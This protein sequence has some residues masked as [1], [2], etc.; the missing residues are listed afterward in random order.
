MGQEVYGMSV[1]EIKQKRTA[2][3]QKSA[4][5]FE[6]LYNEKNGTI[7]LKTH[8][9]WLTSQE[10]PFEADPHHLQSY[11]QSIKR[12][13]ALPWEH[14]FWCLRADQ[15]PKTIQFLKDSK[16]DIHIHELNE[17]LPQMKGRHLYQAY[18][19]H[20]HFCLAS[21]IVRHNIVYLNG[22]IYANLGTLLQEDLTPFAK[23]YDHIWSSNGKCLSQSFFGYQQNDPIIKAYLDSLDRL[24]QMPKA[25]KDLTPTFETQRF[26]CEEPHLMACIDKFSMDNIR[27]L[28]VPE[29]DKSLMTISHAQS[30]RRGNLFGNATILEGKINILEIDPASSSA[31][32]INPYVRKLL[33]DPY[34]KSTGNYAYY[35]HFF[36]NV[37]EKLF[38]T[39]VDNVREKRTRLLQ[40]TRSILD[41][42][43]ETGSKRLSP[44]PYLT[45]RIWLTSDANPFEVPEDRLSLYF[46]SL[47]Q[48]KSAKW[49]H[50]F[51][52]LDPA[53]IPTTIKILE[54]SDC[55]IQIHKLDEV[56]PSFRARDIFWRLY[57]AKYYTAASD[58]ARF[59]IINLKGGVYS[60]FGVEYN[61]DLGPYVERFDYIFGQEGFL[62]GTSFLAAPKNSLVISNLLRFLDTVDRV[63]P[64]FRNFGDGIATPPWTALGILTVMMDLHTRQT[65]RILPCPYGSDSLVKANHMASWLG[66]GKFGQTSLERQ[67]ISPE[68]IFG[69]R[70]LLAKPYR[71]SFTEDALLERFTLPVA[72]SLYKVE[73]AQLEEKRQA[74][75][76]GFKDTYYNLQAGPNGAPI[77]Q[78]SHR[79]WI[80]SEDNPVEVPVDRLNIYLDSIQMLDASPGWQHIFWCMDQTHLPQTVK[81]LQ[82]AKDRLG[83]NI[84]IRDIKDI[85]PSMRG[86]S[87]FEAFYNDKRFCNANDIF[88]LNVLH[89][90]G[91]IY[92]DM[93]CTFLKDLTPFLEIYDRLFFLYDWGNIDHGVCAVKPHDDI[94]DRY[95]NSLE[96]LHLL[97]K[98]VKT[99]T[100]S[101]S[102][103]LTW[104]GSHHLMIML[105]LF[106]KETDKIM[107]IPEGQFL[108]IKQSH[109][110]G[111]SA[112]FGNKSILESKVD[113]FHLV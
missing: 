29:G 47:K 62:A 33:A 8:R 25:A 107:F 58:I 98:S 102:S 11:V 63:H 3:S 19:D 82:E 100:S 54:Q 77:P 27:F 28:F 51:W 42:L 83:L 20:K 16:A 12:L 89:N 61:T 81:F 14:H 70:S 46:Q 40:R 50:H 56:M 90:Q 17:I 52:C 21:H 79:T 38:S 75:Y 24:H 43:H 64:D 57:Q 84:Q 37:Y 18:Y 72:K 55:G 59:N 1:D 9:L 105:D 31:R 91:G 67:P 104:T 65:D 68:I 85:L 23:A 93:G 48:L 78:I 4:A 71:M 109:S 6:N 110:W 60:D 44:I 95:L 2:Q 15:I 49:V 99:L 73:K 30:W 101:A 87:I 76:Q 92:A 26:W 53:K 10:N 106:S 111:I 112:K 36:T 5:I 97:P 13:I 80:T 35:S 96:T 39:T 103:Q 22:G 69:D 113:V 34:D 108:T 32:P 66:D 74:L 7:P 45:H 88:R 86:R 41:V 94:L